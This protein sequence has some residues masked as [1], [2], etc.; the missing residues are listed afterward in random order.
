MYMP[1]LDTVEDTMQTLF[2]AV[3]KFFKKWGWESLPEEYK[4]QPHISSDAGSLN[5]SDITPS[6]PHTDTTGN[7]LAF[8]DQDLPTKTV[9][10]NVIV[11]VIN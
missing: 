2:F 6:F 4:S 11:Y 10:C 8:M 1:G 7:E 5:N 9:S 3:F